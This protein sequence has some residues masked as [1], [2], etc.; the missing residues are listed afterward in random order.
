MNIERLTPNIQLRGR[1]GRHGRNAEGK[2]A[3]WQIA[4]SKEKDARTPRAGDG[5]RKVRELLMLKCQGSSGSGNESGLCGVEAN[6]LDPVVLFLSTAG[7]VFKVDS[8]N[9]RKEFS[10][11]S[12]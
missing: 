7:Q 3:H 6:G 9:G 10:R 2:I 1:K 11:G 4:G 12:H 5:A 8:L